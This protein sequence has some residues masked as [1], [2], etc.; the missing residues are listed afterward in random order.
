MK[1]IFFLLILISLML[2]TIDAKQLSQ[3]VGT[4][5]LDVFTNIDENIKLNQSYDIDV[6]VYNTSNGVPIITNINCFGHLY[7]D[8]NHLGI[9]IDS[10]PSNVF[11]Y[12]LMFNNN[13][14]SEK[15]E[16]ILRVSCNNT[17]KGGRT[18]QS[19]FVT[20]NGYAPV[21]DNFK[22][23]IYIL[24]IVSLMGCLFYLIMSIF[25]LAT[26]TQTIF[27]V[28]SAWTFYLGMILSYYLA[29]NFLLDYFIEDISISVIK[30]G[31][32]PLILIPVFSLIWTM[33]KKGTEKKKPLSPQEL[34]GRYF[35]YG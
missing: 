31:G 5:G 34:T 6:H 3:S 7:K 24:F 20:K 4:E 2:S 9:A 1:R 27:G 8:G 28:L 14:F 22:I 32:F 35:Q 17:I 25:N 30:W 11:D 26:A 15:G 12:E 19:L 10:T 13:N 33:F 16:Y 23:F 29:N 18:S 21:G